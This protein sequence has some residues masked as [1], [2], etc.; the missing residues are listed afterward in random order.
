[1]EGP[2][3]YNKL[4]DFDW[5]SRIVLSSDKLS[6]LNKPIVMLQLTTEDCNGIEKQTLLELTK[7]DTKALLENLT[8]IQKVKCCFI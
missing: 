8:K 7:D 2:A 6:G 4:K 1:M 5:S 3:S